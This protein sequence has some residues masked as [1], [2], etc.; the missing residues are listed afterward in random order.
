[1]AEAIDGSNNGFTYLWVIRNFSR[2]IL[3]DSNLYCPKQF[4]SPTVEVDLLEKRKCNIVILFDSRIIVVS[5]SIFNKNDEAFEPEI[6]VELAFLADDGTILRK[7]KK[8][9]TFPACRIFVL[10]L[11]ANK[12]TVFGPK[13]FEYLPN[14]VLTIRCRIRLVRERTRTPALFIARSEVLDKAESFFWIIERFSSLILGESRTFHLEPK[15]HGLQAMK[16]SI[17]KE[18]ISDDLQIHITGKADKKKDI[19]MFWKFSLIDLLGQ[20][21]IEMP[22]YLIKLLKHSQV[23]NFIQLKIMNELSVNENLHLSNDTLILKGSYM[24]SQADEIVYNNQPDA[25]VNLPEVPES[26]S[27]STLAGDLRCLFDNHDL[28]DGTIH[29]ENTSI[30]IHK[31]ILGA[32]SPVFKAMFTHEMKENMGKSI[33]IPDLDAETVRLM[34]KFI[35]ADI[36]ED[37][38]TESAAS[39]YFAA[40]KYELLPLKNQCSTFLKANLS[41]S[42]VLDV[43]VLA[44]RHHDS[45]LKNL[46][47][48]YILKHEDDLILS[49]QWKNFRMVH[50]DLALDMMEYLH[51]KNAYVNGKAEMNIMTE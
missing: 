48:G 9:D 31:V 14:D 3:N 17:S 26:P 24:I 4:L 15:I 32:R 8:R 43:L 21:T 29:V 39:L 45:D 1:M 22:T 41:L 20:T 49:D 36:V 28:C 40:D 5:C 50:K 34:L 35:Y 16:L 27:S 7:V 46:A 47:K 51:L 18:K 38:Q 23:S 44:D 13:K 2:F 10:Q 12:D 33:D 42:N 11:F 6:E 37:L 30:P 19:C 25:Q